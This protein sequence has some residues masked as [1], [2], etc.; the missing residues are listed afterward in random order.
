MAPVTT[1]FEQLIDE[2]FT[3]IKGVGDRL[4]ARIAALEGASLEQRLKALESRPELVC[5]GVWEPGAYVAGSI[6]TH[7][8]SA[9]IAKATTGSKPGEPHVELRAWQLMVKRGSDGRDMR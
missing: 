2:I 3:T 7:G 8:G 6:V 9:W 1:P 5:R 4:A